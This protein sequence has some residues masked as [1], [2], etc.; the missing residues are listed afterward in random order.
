MK[1][2]II[3]LI[4][5]PFFISCGKVKKES[6]NDSYSNNCY[7][8]NGQEKISN[9]CAVSQQSVV[10]NESTVL[11]ISN[12]GLCTGSIISDNFILTAAHCFFNKEENKYTPIATDLSNVAYGSRIL[13]GNNPFDL[14]NLKYIEVDKIIPNEIFFVANEKDPS[15]LGDVALIK[16]KTSLLKN[17]NTKTIALKRFEVPEN[18]L[19]VSIGFGN[20]HDQVI[21]KEQFPIKRWTISTHK[22]ISTHDQFE[23]EKQ[24]FSDSKMTYSDFLHFMSNKNHIELAYSKSPSQTF[25]LTKITNKSQGKTCS[26]DSGG[27]Q[28]YVNGKQFSQVSITTGYYYKLHSDANDLLIGTD[29]CIEYPYAINT[30]V[31]PYLDWIVKEMAVYGQMPIIID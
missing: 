25:F 12:I 17:Q 7:D 29:M 5:L 6:V 9:G 21:N 4:L 2:K 24:S 11:I 31:A 16:T 8:Y 18:S 14:F 28:I 27:P 23:Y 15:F 30:K 22:K 10:G 19:I 26:G 13:I 1:L 3:S 20:V